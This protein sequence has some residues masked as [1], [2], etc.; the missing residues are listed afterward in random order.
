MAH[1]DIHPLGGERCLVV[2]LGGATF[3]VDAPAAEVQRV[4]AGL[5]GRAP[6]SEMLRRLGVDAAYGEVVETLG[7]ERALLDGPAVEHEVDWT[8]FDGADPA[9]AG[10]VELLLA[11]DAHLVGRLVALLD[12]R[13]RTRVV[14]ASGQPALAPER[15]LA[16][17]DAELEP[18]VVLVRERLDAP[19]LT[20]VDEFLG[21]RGVRW[22][23]LHLQHG[24]GFLGPAI[25]P[26]RTADYRDL[27]ARRRCAVDDTEVFD[28]L[29]APSVGAAYLPPPAELAWMLAAYAADLERWIAGAGCRSL[30]A[31]VQADPVA[32]T[33]TQ[34]WV[35]PLPDRAPPG[36]L[37]TSGPLGSTDLLLGERTGIIQRA[38]TIAHHE[39]LP[40]GLCTVQT[41]N[42]NMGRVDPEWA[43]DVICGGSTFGDPAQARASSI[44]ESIE[45]YCGNYMGQA[46]LRWASFDELTAAGE[47]AI[48]PQTLVLYSERLYDEPGCPFVR[49][50]RDLEVRWVLGAAVADGRPVWLPV[51][52]VFVN[53]LAAE[54]ERRHP[55][56]NYMNF[57]GVTAGR[58][59]DEAIVSGIEELVERDATM[60]WWS[61]AQRLP[62]VIASADLAGLWDRRSMAAGQRPSLIH[63]DNEFEIPVMAGVVH[64]DRDGWLNIGF[65]A[66]PTPEAAAAK[67]WTEA[68]TLQEGS[69][70]LNEKDSL[71]RQAIDWG[72][73]A[74]QGLK[75]WRA[76]RRYLDSYRPDFRDCADLMCQQ[77][78]FLDPRAV[79]QVAPYADTDPERDLAD[80]PRLPDRR[81]AT[82]RERLEGRGFEVFHVDLTT[83][84][85]AAAGLCATRVVV[86]GLVPNWP[87]AF[88]MF[89]GGRVQRVPVD[90]GWRTDALGEGELNLWPLPHA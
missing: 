17:A 18:V 35:L 6:A 24:H 77:Q 51:T 76:D 57:C 29:L 73:A 23:Q 44:G 40:A 47:E 49:F 68:L 42:A 27:L 10:R 43:N 12:G 30:S 41:H 81:L 65:A 3:A 80:L 79:E 84:D 7:A 32:M 31:E 52:I 14:S 78:I 13:L 16:G 62:G 59:M 48:D 86:P 26:G 72:F 11:G 64:N 22:S 83:R 37:V 8:R 34:H 4:L 71:I 25:E 9:A 75:E 36:E 58:T 1:A 60:I 2:T 53:W 63:L 61:N 66:R 45:R 46:T 67:A 70:D 74:Y 55:L 15:L 82:Y 90:L 56:T 88:P 89:G 21:G 5:D 69:R 33:L 28:A 20:A 50:T 38:R 87:A 54:L 85:V 19:W 39:S